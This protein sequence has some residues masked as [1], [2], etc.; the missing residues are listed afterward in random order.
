[1]NVPPSKLIERAIKA[2]DW[3]SARSLIRAELRRDPRNHWL[4]S[5]LAV[6]YYEQR[7]YKH[8]LYWDA[9]ALQEAPFCP[10]AIWGYAGTLDMLNHD[11][12][13]LVLYRW[14]LS[15]GEEDLAYGDCGEGLRSARSLIADCHYRIGRIWEH[16]RQWKKAA[17][18]YEKHLAKRKMGY[19]SIYSIRE[20][21]ARYEKLHTMT[22]R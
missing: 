5:R 1:M 11:G 4:L 8:A 16:R 6:T 2:D 19:S 22:R 13:S 21:K 7:K 9:K 10:L 15:F 20:V 18:E 17:A 14:L 3:I 12:E